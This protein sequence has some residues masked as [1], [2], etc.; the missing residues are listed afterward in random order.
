MTDAARARLVVGVAV[1]RRRGAGW[2]LLAAQRAHPPE[3]AGRWELPGGKVEAGETPEAAVHRE[4]AEEL[5]VEV[6]VLGWLTGE[7]EVRPGLLLRV[8]TAR[9]LAGEPTAREHRAVRWLALP[10][11]GRTGDADELD[12]V[13]WL[14]ADVPFVAE[15]RRASAGAWR[16]VLP[17]EDT[18]TGAASRLRRQGFDVEVSRAPFAGEDDDE[19]HAYAVSTDAPRDVAA[20]CCEAYD[21]W[22]EESDPAPRTAAHRGAPGPVD[23][24]SGPRRLHRAPRT[25]R[26][27][28]G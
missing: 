26:G 21:G 2:E 17:D 3:A 6:E 12:A 28:G 10:G 13:D 23:L 8:A 11:P 16:L 5:G 4:L 1:R 15:L 24:P 18:A 9:L 14:A 19:D 27:A 20:A 25:G 22:L 7:V